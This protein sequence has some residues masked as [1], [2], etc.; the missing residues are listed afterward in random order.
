MHGRDVRPSVMMD[1]I[2][3]MASTSA[4][5]RLRTEEQLGYIVFSFTRRMNAVQGFSVVVQVRRPRPQS[6]QSFRFLKK[7]TWIGGVLGHACMPTRGSCS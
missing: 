7:G 4:Y 3:H 6:K 5:Q 2:S 1:M